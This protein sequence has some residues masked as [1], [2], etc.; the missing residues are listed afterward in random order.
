VWGLYHGGFLVLERLFL[1]DVLARLPRVLQHVYLLLVTMVGWVLFR[2]ETM[3]QAKLWLTAMAGGGA[4]VG[5][6]LHHLD[7]RLVVM[8]LAG[9]VLATPVVPAIAAAWQHRVASAGER[10]S[11]RE[12]VGA[13]V[14]PVLAIALFVWSAAVLSSGTHNPFIYFRF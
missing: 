9:G 8:M 1:G 12:A 2:V 5:S 7:A 11:G 6:A 3:A 4:E 13:V 14:R 10:A